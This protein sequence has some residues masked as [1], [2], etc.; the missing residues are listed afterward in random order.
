LRSRAGRPARQPEAR[1]GRSRASRRQAFAPAPSAS[2]GAVYFLHLT[3]HGLDLRRVA[4]DSTPVRGGVVPVL[5]A[6]ALLPRDTGAA[7][8]SAVAQRPPVPAD[9]F[10]TGTVTERAYGAGARRYSL[11]PIGGVSPDG[12]AGGAQLAAIDPAGRLSVLAQAVASDPRVWGG[13]S[14]RAAW[15]G[16]PV[17]LTGELFAARQALG[18]AAP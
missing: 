4:P 17:T 16:L 9:T 12:S 15:R 8:R 18:A 6:A 13:G 5:A 7:V 2:E 1:S 11:L 3:P 14:L 10:A